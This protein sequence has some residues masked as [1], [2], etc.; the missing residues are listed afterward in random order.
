MGL[1]AKT[2]KV[3]GMLERRECKDWKLA[4][5]DMVRAR[6]VRR[7]VFDDRGIARLE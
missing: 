3:H 5:M 1:C 7:V 4:A 2:G 6:M